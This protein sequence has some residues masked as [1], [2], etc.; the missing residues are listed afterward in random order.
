MYCAHVLLVP[1]MRRCPAWRGKPAWQQRQAVP[2]PLCPGALCCPGA[3]AAVQ[4]SCLASAHAVRVRLC[5]SPVLPTLLGL[6]QAACAERP[7]TAPILV[8]R[9]SGSVTTS[10]GQSAPP[11]LT[12]RQ[13]ASYRQACSCMRPRSPQL[14]LALPVP[15]AAA[16]VGMP[17]AADVAAAAARLAHCPFGP[18]RCLVASNP[19]R[20]VL[21]GNPKC[22]RR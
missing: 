20:L 13:R 14:C 17:V 3:V 9:G 11:C 2:R 10:N 6:S 4:P 18:L 15:S 22:R 1:P 5:S 21:A 8:Q 16:C 12:S 19:N 7:I